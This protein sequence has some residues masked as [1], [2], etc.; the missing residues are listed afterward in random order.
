VAVLHLEYFGFIRVAV[1]MDQRKAL[2]AASLS[3][4]ST[5]NESVMC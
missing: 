5:H 1:V 2:K 4:V 3:L